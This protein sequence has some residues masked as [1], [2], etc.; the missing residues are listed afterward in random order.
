MTLQSISDTITVNGKA[1]TTVYDSAAGTVIST[2]PEG[3]MRIREIDSLGRIVGARVGA[4]DSV[5]Y[6]YDNRGRLDSMAYGTGPEARTRSFAYNLQ[7]YPS[8][9]TDEAGRVFE[10][11]YDAAGRR[12]R[13]LLPDSQEIL[14]AYDS[15]GNLDSLT[16][17]GSIPHAFVYTALELDSIYA[18]PSLGVGVWS[19]S[20]RYNLDRQVSRLTKPESTHVDIEYDTAGRVSEV[21]IPGGTYRYS[22]HPITGK[23]DSILSRDSVTSTFEYDGPLLTRET[24]S[25]PVG[26]EV[27]FSYNADFRLDTLRVNDSAAAFDYDDD[28]LLVQADGLSLSYLPLNALLNRTLIN[29]IKDTLAYNSFGEL[30][31]QESRS[32]GDLLYSAEFQRDKLGRIVQKEEIIESDT[33]LYDYGYDLRGRLIEVLVDSGLYSRYQYDGNGNRLARIVPSDTLIGTYDDQDRLIQYGDLEMGYTSN[34][35]LAHLISNGDTTRYAYDALGNLIS[36][37]L[38]GGPLVE[39]LID[40][41]NRRVG[42]KMNGILVQGFLYQDQLNPVAE[43]DGSGN[44]I[45][46]FVYGSNPHTPDLVTKAGVVY[47]VI[48]D[49]LGSPRLIVNAADGDIVQ[50]IAYDEFGNLMEDSNPGFQPF[51]FAGGIYDGQTGLIRFGARDYFPW[52]GRWTNKDPIG[53]GGKSLNLYAYVGNDPLNKIDPQGLEP[54]TLAD[55]T[56]GLIDITGTM[57]DFLKNMDNMID[58]NTIGA[59]KYFHCMA[60]C[61]GASRGPAGEAAAEIIS[62]V[63]EWTDENSP[64][65]PD[66]P[67]SC[68]A[69]QKANKAG[70]L[71]GSIGRSCWDVCS[72]FRP[73]ALGEEF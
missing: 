28:G 37:Q 6:F 29:G 14:F 9:L 13:T 66:H 58:A 48:S 24:W 72:D 7:G 45:S 10:F 49:H 47:K 5:E 3:R 51:G 69:D 30:I 59:D 12:T 4:L 34:G 53:F 23:I 43:L 61:E 65:E 20:R 44:I 21:R 19:T 39:Y 73:D 55:L 70:R 26:G 25:G 22:Y 63:R 71:G 40:G 1:F 64:F 27:E 33:I 52:V 68:A 11:E 18:P 17:P 42:K 38:P 32:G 31:R 54:V 60:N 41:K 2:S 35:E 62:D 50:R 15:S 8:R 56:G 16:P 67:D 57:S 36:V 46:R